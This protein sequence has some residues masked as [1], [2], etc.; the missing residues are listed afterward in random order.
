[1]RSSFTTQFMEAPSGEKYPNHTDLSRPTP[2]FFPVSQVIASID[3]KTNTFFVL[4]PYT[5]RRSNVGVVRPAGRAAHLRTHADG[6]W[7]DNLLSLDHCPL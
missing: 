3:A 5:G 1:M 6:D 2:N 7:N 4:D